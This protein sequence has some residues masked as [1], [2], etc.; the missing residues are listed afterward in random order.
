M[1]IM[2]EFTMPHR[3]T[4]PLRERQDTYLDDKMRLCISRSIYCGTGAQSRVTGIAINR[5]NKQDYNTIMRLDIGDSV[6]VKSGVIDPELGIEIGG[7][8]GR[9]IEADDGD[10]VFIRWD[11]I[12]LQKMGLDLTIQ[13]ENENLNWELMT[14]DMAEVQ[15]AASRDTEKDVAR[16]ARQLKNEMIG[17]PRLERDEE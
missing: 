15:K 1:M 8:Q 7:W 2:A 5:F 14:L 3:A 17:D 10:S 6:V 13:C 12:T 16:I 4:L 9:I 11:S